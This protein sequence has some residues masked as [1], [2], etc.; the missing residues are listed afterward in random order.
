ME[1][2]SDYAKLASDFLHQYETY[3][4]AFSY[5]EGYKKRGLG[6]VRVVYPMITETGKHFYGV[7]YETAAF[8]EEH[9]APHLKDT[10]AAGWTLEVNYDPLLSFV[11]L[12]TNPN[13]LVGGYA[14]AHYYPTTAP[15]DTIL[16][17]MM[18]F[19]T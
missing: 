19:V 2:Q 16:A 6:V 17:Q 11:V 10:I 14:I 4:S 8:F 9:T 7:G 12:F 18:E 1:N 3:L 5:W 13:P 15:K